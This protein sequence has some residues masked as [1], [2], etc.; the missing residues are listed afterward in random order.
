MQVVEFLKGHALS[1]AAVLGKRP[2]SHIVMGALLLAAFLGLTDY[3]LGAEISLGVFYAVPVVMT[4]WFVGPRSAFAMGLLSISFWLTAD[5]ADGLLY[6]RPWIPF[7][8]GA[9]RLMFYGFLII[10]LTQLR[11]LQENL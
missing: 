11:H 2:K 6:S 8:N 10:I 4:A 3:L 5:Y 7:V 9:Y 1:L